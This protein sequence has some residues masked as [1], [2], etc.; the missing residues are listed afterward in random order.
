MFNIFFC[1]LEYFYYLCFCSSKDE[2]ARMQSPAL[3]RTTSTHFSYTTGSDKL[4]PKQ[5]NIRYCFVCDKNLGYI[6][7]RC[8][9]DRYMCSEECRNYIC[10]KYSVEIKEI[11]KR[12]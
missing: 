8:I 6:E 9:C 1:I 10:N 2:K 5:D 11:T 3:K 12:R 7:V 4:L